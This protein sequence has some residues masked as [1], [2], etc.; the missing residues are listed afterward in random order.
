MYKTSCEDALANCSRRGTRCEQATGKWVL[1]VTI[2]GSS[3]AFID[4]TIV[5]VILPVIQQQL[6]AGVNEVQWVLESYALF[7]AAL[8][9]VGG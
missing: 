7:L 3:M 1:L 6:G 4:G 8:I 9:L 2:L 5:N